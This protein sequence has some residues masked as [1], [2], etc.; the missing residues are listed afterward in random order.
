M[1]LVLLLV[2]LSLLPF[3]IHLTT[4]VK[5]IVVTKSAVSCKDISTQNT[6]NDISKM[7]NIVDVRQSTGNENVPFTLDW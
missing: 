5:D 3:N 4:D 7:R 2:L 1:E 6:T